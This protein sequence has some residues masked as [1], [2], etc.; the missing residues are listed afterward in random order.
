MVLQRKA[1][2]E[3]LENVW[4]MN[5]ADHPE[6]SRWKKW[7][8]EYIGYNRSGEAVTFVV[9]WNGRDVG[10]GTLLFSPACEAV[11]GRKAL[12]DGIAV[13]NIN[14]LRIR[15]ECEGK[16]YIS[17]MIR[18]MEQYARENGYTRLTIG[19]EAAETRNLGIYLHWG[20]NEFVMAETEENTL[21]LYYA[22]NL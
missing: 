14:A 7:K 11:G 21:I 4:N 17:A 15:K 3:D 19:V 16:G 13:A 1:T 20:Y 12:A 6:D 9:I 8:Q 18:Q 5:I 22:K 10:E 2:E